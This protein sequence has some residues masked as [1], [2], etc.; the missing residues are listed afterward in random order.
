MASKSGGAAKSR[1]KPGTPAVDAGLLAMGM[2]TL[3]SAARAAGFA[4][5]TTDEVPAQSSA[6]A[7]PEA[8]TAWQSRE[9][10]LSASPKA[11]SLVD[12]LKNPFGIFGRGAPA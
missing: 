7:K 5:A 2:E 6:E 11:T 12:W 1:S 10:L 3:N 9:A 4:M 8:R